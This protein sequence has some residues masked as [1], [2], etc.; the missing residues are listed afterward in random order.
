MPR[1]RRGFPGVGRHIRVAEV[2]AL[3][4][5]VHGIGRGGEARGG[6]LDPLRP[7]EVVG[8]DRLESHGRQDDVRD[9]VLGAHL[10]VRALSLETHGKTVTQSLDR[11]GVVQLVTLHG[12]PFA[13]GRV[14]RQHAAAVDVD[15]VS[16]LRQ[17]PLER[18]PC[19]ATL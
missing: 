19:T 12:M 17:T 11:I 5:D 16:L 13:L 10:H 7:L 15:A 9:K 4:D 18:G 8:R 1:A 6:A 14:E 3:A 2:A